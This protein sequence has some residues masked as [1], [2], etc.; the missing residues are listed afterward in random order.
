M[1]PTIS[2]KTAL[3]RLHALQYYYKN[4]ANFNFSE[5]DFINFV[6]NNQIT[7]FDRI[8]LSKKRGNVALSDLGVKRN[9]TRIKRRRNSLNE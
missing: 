3:S 4:R 8:I 2:S 7:E 5:S 9:S 1:N 6:R